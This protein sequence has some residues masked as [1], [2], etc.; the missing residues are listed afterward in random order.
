MTSFA[1]VIGGSIRQL[2]AVYDNSPLSALTA[3]WEDVR[4]KNTEDSFAALIHQRLEQDLELKFR[5]RTAKGHEQIRA[6]AALRSRGLL[7]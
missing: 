5:Y 7:K 2:I 3:L 1:L 4:V 6:G